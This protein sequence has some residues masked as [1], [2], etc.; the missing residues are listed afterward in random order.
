M[1][2]VRV[3]TRVCGQIGPDDWDMFLKKKEFDI[4]EPISKIKEFI[5]SFT[6]KN[7]THSNFIIEIKDE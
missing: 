5:D 7:T 2:K 4:N 3:Y 6:F 1:S